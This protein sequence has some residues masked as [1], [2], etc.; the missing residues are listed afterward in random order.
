MNGT[1]AESFHTSSGKSSDIQSLNW[2]CP[3]LDDRVVNWTD[4]E[5]SCSN[6]FENLSGV[7]DK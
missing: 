2:G 7:T 3:G 6:C 4:A 5:P 1:G